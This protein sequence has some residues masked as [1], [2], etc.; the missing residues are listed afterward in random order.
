MVSPQPERFSW[1]C[2]VIFKIVTFYN[3]FVFVYTHST[4]MKYKRMPFID[5]WMWKIS[6]FK[7]WNHT[8]VHNTGSPKKGDLQIDVLFRDIQSENLLSGW[9]MKRPSLCKLLSFSIWQEGLAVGNK[10][11]AMQTAQKGSVPLQSRSTDGCWFLVFVLLI[12]QG[13]LSSW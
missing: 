3:V 12:A 4:Q 13:S 7:S 9:W 11:S 8:S 6:I 1:C 2:F 10:Y 5:S